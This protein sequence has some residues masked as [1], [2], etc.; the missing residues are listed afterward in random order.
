MQKKNIAIIAGGDSSEREVSFRSAAGISSFI[1]KQDYNTFIISIVDRQWEVKIT[2]QEI[3]PID[4]N[5]FSFERNGKKIVF[6]FAFI[7]IHG[8]PGENGL[9][10]GY[11]E[12]MHIPYSTCNTL[13]SA[14]T[15]NKFWNN[16][17][18]KG[19]GIKTPESVLIRAENQPDI[20]AITQAVG[21][22]C[23]VKPNQGGSSFGATIVKETKGLQD[24]IT[25]AF[26]EGDEVIVE[27]L[28]KG[29]EFTCGMYKTKTK[30]VIFPITEIISDNDFF[31]YNAKYNKQSQEIT[32]ARISTALSQRISTL[33]NAIYDILNCKGIIRADYIISNQE[34][35]TLL[36]VNTT[37]GM[38][39]TSFI[40]QQVVAA[41]LNIKNVMSDIIEDAF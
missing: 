38:T 9:L 41:Q 33:T 21:I 19:F 27:S 39:A 15:F 13:T 22:P 5:D 3:Y 35:I 11:F 10:Q 8:T 28:I 6:D 16:H 26:K 2:E 36:E 40:P 20:A 29:N 24:A 14:L 23:F 4:K 31:D 12:L 17:Y 32:P 37:P 7:T 25:N 34:E 30:T 18:L 1:D